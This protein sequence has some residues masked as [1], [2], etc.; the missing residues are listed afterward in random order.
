VL[1][2]RPV[3]P[4]KIYDYL[5]AQQAE[6][7]KQQRHRFLLADG[8]PPPEENAPRILE[9]PESH[10]LSWVHEM[11]GDWHSVFDE[12]SRLR[13]VVTRRLEARRAGVSYAESVR[14]HQTGI[15]WLDHER[16]TKPSAVGEAMRRLWHRTAH[17]GADPPWHHRSVGQRVARRLDEREHGK[18]R[19]LAEA[20][21]EG[22]ISAPFTFSDTVL[23]SGTV[24]EGSRV[25]VWEAS[26]RYLLS[27]TIGCY[28]VKPEMQRSDT[29]GAEA[30]DQ[31]DDGDA[32]KVL[33]PS[34]EKLCFP[35]F[36][37]LLPTMQTFRLTTN[38]EGIDLKSL[39]YEE[40]CTR[41]G[42]LQATAREIE[43]FGYDPRSEDPFLPNAAI[44][45]SAEAVDA[46]LNAARSGRKNESATASAGH[47]LCSITQLGG[48]LYVL[49]I[50]VIAM[51]LLSFLPVVNFF[52]QL[53]FDTTTAAAA[54]AAGSPELETNASGNNGRTVVGDKILSGA[55]SFAGSASRLNKMRLPRRRVASIPTTSKSAG[56]ESE[57]GRLLQSTRVLGQVA[58]HRAFGTRDDR[59]PRGI[60]GAIRALRNRAWTPLGWQMHAPVS[61]PTPPI[62]PEAVEVHVK[63]PAPLSEAPEGCGDTRSEG[64]T[65]ALYRALSRQGVRVEHGV[66][67]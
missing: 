36:P 15:E 62:T 1:A 54:F 67:L 56:T 53:C 39:S 16:Y 45:R 13:D 26:L 40:Y 7:S 63:R 38:T 60:G 47:I 5:E 22:T 48:V 4:H 44:L 27:S 29:Q 18:L 20:F 14:K 6:R 9:L 55:S 17:E 8:F 49:F 24:I 58:P 59:R 43:T 33:R 57:T 46:V 32:L 10:A 35:A 61:P 50:L 19:R 23:P 64:I 31:G 42:V 52:F 25:S 3:D 11:V 2:E 41:D 12:A 28:F 37:F 30:G 66:P 65:G 51:V 34:A 21:L